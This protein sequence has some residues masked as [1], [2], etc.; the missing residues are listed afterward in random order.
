[1]LIA[2]ASSIDPTDLEARTGWSIRPEG[3]CQGEVCVPLPSGPL[4]AAMLSDRLGMAIVNNETHGLTALGPST[5]A[6]RALESVD[7]PDV[8][9]A[10]FDGNEVRLADVTGERAV[11][12]S[13]A[14]W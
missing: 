4:T 13:W 5:V 6:G 9:L 1:M 11:I 8:T 10:D 12:V 3:A 7:V 2:D 14:P